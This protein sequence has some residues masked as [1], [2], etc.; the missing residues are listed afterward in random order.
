M[1]CDG[2]SGAVQVAV[3]KAPCTEMQI[4]SRI[5]SIMVP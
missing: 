4:A 3:E 2:A 1:I 5:A